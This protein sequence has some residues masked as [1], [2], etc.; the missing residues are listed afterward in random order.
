MIGQNEK[1][2]KYMRRAIELARLAMKRGDVPV[3]AVAV[4]EDDEKRGIVSEIVGEGYNR[5]E[6]DKNAL[7]HAELIAINNACEA[8]G[9]WRLHKCTLYVTL[10]P[11]TMCAGAINSARVKRVVYGAGDKK[12]GALGGKYDLYKEDLC[13]KTEVTGGVLEEECSELLGEFFKRLREG[14][15]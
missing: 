6:A 8:L 2:I 9:G 10:E 1:D 7:L 3:G 11:C 13:H 14:K 4:W 15:I 12:L 5:R